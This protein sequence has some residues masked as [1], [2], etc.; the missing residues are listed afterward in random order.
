MQ[1]RL[2]RYNFAGLLRWCKLASTPEHEVYRLPLY[3]GD[4]VTALF[5]AMETLAAYIHA[6]KTGE[7][8]V[9]DV[10]QFEAIARIIEM[11]YTMYYNLGVLREKE[12]V[13]KVFNQQPY[14][15]YKA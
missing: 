11:Y 8:Q 7:G 3:A 5:W 9:V 2:L 4:Y 1:E 12:G 6:Q 14:G 13:Y 15:L 10:A